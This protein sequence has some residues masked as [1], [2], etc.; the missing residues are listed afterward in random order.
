[1]I[2]RV[3]DTHYSAGVDGLAAHVERN[4]RATGVASAL[5]EVGRDFDVDSISVRPA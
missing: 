2:I 5:S 3:R 1:V 4:Q